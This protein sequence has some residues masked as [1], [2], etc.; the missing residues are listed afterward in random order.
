MAEG[1]I[2]LKQLYTPMTFQ[3]FV[4]VNTEIHQ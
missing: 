3:P 1:S 2:N 4:N